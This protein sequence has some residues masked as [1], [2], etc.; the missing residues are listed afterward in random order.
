MYSIIFEKE[1][2]QLFLQTKSIMTNKSGHLKFRETMAIHF[3]NFDTLNSSVC[4]SNKLFQRH[5]VI[6]TAQESQTTLLNN[7]LQTLKCVNSWKMTRKCYRQRRII[8]NHVLGETTPRNMFKHSYQNNVSLRQL[9]KHTLLAGPSELLT[10][11]ISGT[12]VCT[13]LPSSLTQALPGQ[14]MCLRILKEVGARGW[15]LTVH[16][17]SLSSS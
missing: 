7:L 4:K 16:P 6:S 14:P 5:P 12:W 11:Q 13:F 2:R 17:P 3:M 8:F 1:Y 9:G 10:Q 15:V